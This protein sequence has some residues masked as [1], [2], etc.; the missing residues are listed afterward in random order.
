MVKRQSLAVVSLICLALVIGCSRKS[1]SNQLR[2][3]SGLGLGQSNA[4]YPF[5]DPKY[6]ELVNQTS[7]ENAKTGM[8]DSSTSSSITSKLKDATAAVGSALTL[9]P[10]VIPANDP[11][12]LSSKPGKLSADLYYQAA[13]VAEN[14]GKTDQAIVKYAQAL[15]VEEDHLPSL[16]GL[17]RLYDR[18]GDFESAITAY[19]KTT[20]LVPDNAMARNDLGLCFARQGRN[21]EAL[22]ELRKAIELEPS[23]KL[24]RNN[25]ATVLVDMG[26]VNAALAEMNAVHPPAI[27]QYNLAYLLVKSG[28]EME[29]RPYLYQASQLDPSMTVAVDLLR[30]IDSRLNPAAT[31]TAQRIQY[32]MDDQQASPQPSSVYA[33]PV[34]STRLPATAASVYAPVDLRRVPPTNGETSTTARPPAAE[35]RGPVPSEQPGVP[36]ANQIPAMPAPND[37]GQLQF[38]VR[39]MSGYVVDEE[40]QRLPMPE[41]LEPLKPA[42]QQPHLLPAAKATVPVHRTIEG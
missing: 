3:D 15:Q 11:V 36:R 4:P 29:A 20:E 7:G 9:K 1:G 14:N 41:D 35:L 33:Q 19:R 8:F 16:I 26:D 21:A 39:T 24:Y 30:Q 27:A 28:H 6:Q 38:P 18:K 40:A 12:A 23:R 13:R 31:A 34:G 10:K 37:G 5:N 32:R 22:A 2:S 42:T 17:A 25:L